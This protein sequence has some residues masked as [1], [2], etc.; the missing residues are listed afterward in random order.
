MNQLQ[1]AYIVYSGCRQKGCTEQDDLLRPYSSLDYAWDEPA[2][3]H[4]LVLELPGNRRL[5]E[6]DLDKVGSQWPVTVAATSQRPEQQR[7]LVCVRADG[8]KRVLELI[9]LQV[10]CSKGGLSAQAPL[11]GHFN[12]C[13]GVASLHG[14]LSVH[15][16][17]IWGSFHL[18]APLHCCTPLCDCHCALIPICI[19]H[20]PLHG[21]LSA[22]VP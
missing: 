12:L 8:P 10:S 6:Y 17:L 5:G 16:S 13:K 2:L 1:T 4:K 14:G 22:C 11:C 3:P 15:M 21:C 20:R 18:K 7:I 19:G 9:D